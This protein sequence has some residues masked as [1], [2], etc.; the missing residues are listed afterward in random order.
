MFVQLVYSTSATM[1]GDVYLADTLVL[2]HVLFVLA[3]Q[4]HLIYVSHLLVD[5][6]CTIQFTPSFCAI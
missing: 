4:C 6:D 2:C 1:E 5:N 3:F